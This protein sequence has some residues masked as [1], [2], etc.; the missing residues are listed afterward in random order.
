MTHPRPKPLSPTR[1]ILEILELDANEDLLPP[2]SDP[3][4]PLHRVLRL[5][6]FSWSRRRSLREDLTRMAKK[7]TL[8]RAGLGAPW[9][10]WMR[11]PTR[12]KAAYAMMKA[13]W[14]AACTLRGARPPARCFPTVHAD[15]FT[16]T[17]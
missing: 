11:V 1:A 4:E 5:Y 10:C 9:A 8:T 15:G 16:P 14:A 13:G 7:V 6:P 17:A 12:I 2:S 3:P